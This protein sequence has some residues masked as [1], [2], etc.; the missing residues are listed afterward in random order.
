MTIATTPKV[1][2]S[3]IRRALI[4]AG[5]GTVASDTHGGDGLI[6]FYTYKTSGGVAITFGCQQGQWFRFGDDGPNTIAALRPVMLASYRRTLERAGYTNIVEYG[7]LIR[8][9]R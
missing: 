4:D 8:V 6:G 5:H 1:T 3:A 2:E 7:G 9:D